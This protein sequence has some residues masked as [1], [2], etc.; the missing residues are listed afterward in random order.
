MRRSPSLDGQDRAV[1]PMGSFITGDSVTRH[2]TRWSGT[3]ATW[4]LPPASDREPLR[5]VAS[6]SGDEERELTLGGRGTARARILTSYGGP[7]SEMRCVGIL[8]ENGVTSAHP[9]R[10]LLAHTN[11]GSTLQTAGRTRLMIG[12]TALMGAPRCACGGRVDRPRTLAVE[13]R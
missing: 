10:C 3:F 1:C 13:R 8:A 11:D 6:M 12:S 7:R 2:T 4:C 5:C 9:S